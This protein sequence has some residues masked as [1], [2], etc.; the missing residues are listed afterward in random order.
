[1]KKKIKDIN[2]KSNNELI[3][4]KIEE[5]KKG[6]NQKNEGKIDEKNFDSIKE[7][8]KYMTSSQINYDDNNKENIDEL[9][10]KYEKEFMETNEKN[11]SSIFYNIYSDK[12]RRFINNLEKILINETVKDF[13]KLK[14]IFEDKEFQSLDK[15]IL[16]ICL[17]TIKGK[18]K[19]EILKEIDTLLELLKI[20]PSKERK[21]KAIDSLFYLSNKDDIINITYSILIF[22]DNAN[23]SKGN[24]W[25][26]VNEIHQNEKKLNNPEELINYIDDLKKN[27]IDIDILY[28]K[29]YKQN[30]YLNIIF[31]L[32]EKPEAIPFLLNKNENDCYALQ[33]VAR[34]DG[35]NILNIE[36]IDYFTKCVIFMKNFGC[37]EKMKDS[38]F[39]KIFKE[40]VKE[41]KDIQL[42]FSHYVNIYNNLNKLFT[43]K[44]D[45]SAASTE[46]IISICQNS[47]FI[48][49][50]KLHHFFKGYY[51]E[52]IQVKLKDK[53][54]KIEKIF[55]KLSS[56]RKLRDR[57]LLTI[58][59][60]NDTE[61][62]P[63]F[64]KFKFFLENINAIFKIYDLIKEI[65][66]SGCMSEIEIITTFTN[67]KINFKFRNLDTS[68][69][70]TAT[71][72]ISKMNDIFKKKQLSAYKEM[73]LIR[74][75]YGRQIK[76]I[77]DKIYKN[78]DNDILPLLKYISNNSIINIEK[79][80]YKVD[81]G[82]DFYYNI[83]SYLK[84]IFRNNDIDLEKINENNNKI[85]KK[86]VDNDYRGIYCFQAFM[87]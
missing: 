36:N 10:N 79:I 3:D 71:K 77:Y 51:Y 21:D 19:E 35:Y 85:M 20:H 30:N 73:P 69:S 86:D 48:L 55:I 42:Y 57:I 49:K 26:L 8:I 17:K 23:L 15:D 84:T 39:F 68:I 50:N 60:S 62:N 33:E 76:L 87:K 2:E 65:Y 11:K 81:T 43:E 40:K 14:E 5:S 9:F 32:K 59:D 53:I 29:N 27:N 80:Y 13:Q 67:F 56:L 52:K 82:K 41:T 4:S 64:E 70:E 74:Y 1:M 83:D 7:F 47:V 75:I 6:H 37:I 22:I 66:T 24:L 18:N 28:D 78:K 72:I 54:P 58:I 31:D 16:Q 44:F 25:K 34:D 45:E 38:D 46:K 63:N 61:R 12:K